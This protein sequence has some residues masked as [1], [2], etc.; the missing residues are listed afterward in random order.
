M[1][2]MLKRVITAI[3]A[4]VLLIGAGAPTATAN[5][6]EAS[7]ILD[8][9]LIEF[10][11][12]PQIMNGRTMVPLRFV[13]EAMGAQFTWHGSAQTID[14][15]HGST[16][17]V[18][19][20][21][22]NTMFVNGVQ[23]TIDQAP[24][25]V[26]GRTLVP[27][28]FIAEAFGA[29]VSW[30]GPNRTAIIQS[31]E[32]QQ[33]QQPQQPGQPGRIWRDGDRLP[34]NAPWDQS[35]YRNPNPRNNATTNFR[36]M[37]DYRD[38]NDN[39]AWPANNPKVYWESF[40]SLSENDIRLKNMFID[41]FANAWDN[42]TLSQVMPFNSNYIREVLRDV[43]I[44]FA[45]VSNW[46]SGFY[47]R[48]P[49]TDINRMFITTRDPRHSAHAATHIHEVGRALGLNS[50]LTTL[51]K[52]EFDEIYDP[53]PMNMYYTTSFDGALLNTVGAEQF[54]RAAFTSN[55]EYTNLFNNHMPLSL[56]D[57][58][59]FR[60]LVN[61]QQMWDSERQ[62]YQRAGGRLSSEELGNIMGKFA[63]AFDS[64]LPREWQ[65]WGEHVY[66]NI[67]AD[68]ILHII[69]RE[70]N[71]ARQL[72]LPPIEPSVLDY[73]LQNTPVAIAQREAQMANQRET[74]SNGVEGEA[75]NLV[76]VAP[77]D[78]AE[79]RNNSASPRL[80]S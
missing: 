1:N 74:N 34:Q 5:P 66:G 68:E 78:Q 3:L 7:I 59:I 20:I 30:D 9:K 4:V 73:I 35:Q 72:E 40:P 61:Q 6:N 76:G 52:H 22:S 80:L 33:G 46:G 58:L 51:L 54:W 11:V 64:G 8:G 65:E 23:S 32:H 26:S 13:G 14:I 10:D 48:N 25:I 29:G 19:Q 50:S 17:I 56:D 43:D 49:F 70:A 53:L 42:D 27:L 2:E 71:I 37:D 77:W 55:Q 36:L 79:Y 12:P 57:A 67:D 28:R 45:S 63:L 16:E 24:L 15:K 31:H 60:S 69:Q 39:H 47:D 75:Q 62:R 21:G 38:F 44:Y 18:M 41:V